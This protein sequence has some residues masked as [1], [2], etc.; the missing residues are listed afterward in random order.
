MHVE[1]HQDQQMMNVKLTYLLPGKGIPVYIFEEGMSFNLQVQKKYH[2]FTAG[3]QISQFKTTSQQTF[4][5]VG[6]PSEI[7]KQQQ[8]RNRMM[9]LI[10]TK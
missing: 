8:I 2:I 1:P 5:E 4:H 6:K 7:R 3:P 10:I 9:L